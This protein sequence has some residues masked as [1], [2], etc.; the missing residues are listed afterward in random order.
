MCVAPLPLIEQEQRTGVNSA[1]AGFLQEH[2]RCR[3]GCGDQPP[4]LPP[5]SVEPASAQDFA[6]PCGSI[7]A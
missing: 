7:G 3:A 5:P 1:F 2:A 6:R 4:A